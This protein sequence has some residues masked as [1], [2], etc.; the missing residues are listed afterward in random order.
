MPPLRKEAREETDSS[1]TSVTIT[2]IPSAAANSFLLL[3]AGVQTTG[4][5]QLLPGRLTVK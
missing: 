1:L 2:P 5:Q 4:L 3:W